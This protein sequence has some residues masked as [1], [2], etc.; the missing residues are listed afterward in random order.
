MSSWTIQPIDDTI[1]RKLKKPFKSNSN[2]IKN[3]KSFI[4]EL[5]F[6]D[7]PAEMGDRKHGKYKDCF[8]IHMTKSISLLYSVSYTERTVYLIDLD[9]HKNLYG[10]DNRSQ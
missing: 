5:E 4:Q 6:I 10:R 9:D 2:L 1:D 3:Y 7:D 8:G